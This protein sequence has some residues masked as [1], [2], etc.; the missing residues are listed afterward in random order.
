MRNANPEYAT[1]GVEAI[2]GGQ[3]ASY[4]FD[5]DGGRIASPDSRYRQPA[6]VLRIEGLVAI[7]LRWMTGPP[8]SR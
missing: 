7:A 5:R 6:N 4:T 2:P 1:L 3:V 8:A